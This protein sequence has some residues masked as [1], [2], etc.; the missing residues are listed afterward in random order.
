GG[1]YSDYLFWFVSGRILY[2]ARPWELVTEARFGD[3]KYANQTVSATDLA[4][5]HRQELSTAVRLEREL[6]RHL[7]VIASY[8][9][10]Q[11]FSNDPLETYNVNTFTGSLQY[12]F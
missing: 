9:Y 5:R 10:E 6:R 1:G 12:E 4:K 8:E 11:T 3:Y 7:K 2:R